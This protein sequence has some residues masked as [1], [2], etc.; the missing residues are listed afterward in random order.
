MNTIIKH[1]RVRVGEP[2]STTPP[3]LPARSAA[4]NAARNGTR[5]KKS[6]QLLREEDVVRAIE[7]RCSCGEITVVEITYGSQAGQES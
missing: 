7:M 2:S 3:A 1:D 4:A 5:C 6:V